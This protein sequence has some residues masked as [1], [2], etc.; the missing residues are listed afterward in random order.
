MLEVK[1][2]D[3]KLNEY[4]KIIEIYKKSFPKNEK[5]PVF[6]LNIMSKR[7]C[8][9]FLAFYDNDTFCGFTYLVNDKNMT[10][11]LYLA[12][13]DSIRSNGYGS[14]IIRWIINNK[15]D[16]IVLNIE[17]VDKQYNNYEQR[18]IRQKFYLKN[19]FI[20]TGYNIKDREDI[21]DVLYKGNNFIKK[22]YENLIKSFS[23]NF[24][25]LKL[26]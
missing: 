7:E 26:K 14:K 22:E 5:L 24:I 23:F 21:Y 8:V 2:I 4:K 19:G 9:D 11:V 15:K 17:E 13:D 1:K 6:L 16:N 3:K 25:Q 20:D 12:V 10:F 18:L